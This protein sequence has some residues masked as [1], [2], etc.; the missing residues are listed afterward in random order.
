MEIADKQ[1]AEIENAEKSVDV[2]AM[3]K[4]RTVLRFMEKQN[5]SSSKDARTNENCFRC[6]GPFPHQNGKCPAKGKTCNACHKTGHFA[7]VCRTPNKGNKSKSKSVKKLEAAAC[8]YSDSDS[9][10]QSGT[11]DYIFGLKQINSIT[12]SQPKLTVKIKGFPA[13]MIVDS[14]SSNNVIDEPTFDKIKHKVALRRADTRVF[15]YG[16]SK[17]LQIVEKFEATIENKTKIGVA[18]IYVIKGNYGPLLKTKLKLC[19]T[20]FRQCSLG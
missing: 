20:N 12:I 3:R 8:S 16:S 19:A 5:V 14:E 10:S 15:A 4:R 11:E 6:G 9:D 13:K 18:D 1:A 7:S 17:T 2:N